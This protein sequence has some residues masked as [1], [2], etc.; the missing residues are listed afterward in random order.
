VARFTDAIGKILYSKTSEMLRTDPIPKAT[1]SRAS[2]RG[3]S[4]KLARRPEFSS[5]S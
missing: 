5:S 2:L 4:S 3:T 1:G